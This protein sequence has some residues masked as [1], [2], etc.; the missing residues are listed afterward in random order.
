MMKKIVSIMLC[1][2]AATSI[3]ACGGAPKVESTGASVETSSGS[4][5]ET[6]GR[7]SAETSAGSSA[8]TSGSSSAEISDGSSAE[9]SAGSPVETSGRPSAAPSGAGLANPFIECATIEEAAKAAGFD[10]TLPSSIPDG[11]TEPKIRAVSNTMIE[12]IYTTSEDKLTARKAAKTGDISGD[13][14]IYAEEESVDV[15]DLKVE[16]K[17]NDGNVS[18]ATWTDGDYSYSVSTRTGLA[19]DI[20]VKLVGEIR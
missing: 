15:G 2:A 20:M 9:T 14:N 18:V 13:Y 10:F 4:S 12:V 7:P 8:Q 17:G 19:R 5:V 11:Y 16:L 3:T 1:L 6:S